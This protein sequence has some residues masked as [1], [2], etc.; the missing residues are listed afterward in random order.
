ML[1]WLA[2]VAINLGKEGIEPHLADLLSPVYRELEL[3]TT[4]KGKYSRI[5]LIKPPTS[6]QN[7]IVFTG[8]QAMS[9]L[10]SRYRAAVKQAT[11]RTFPTL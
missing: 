3:G 1:R 11:K 9:T 2:A 4:Y 8:L 6:Q 10:S 5:P 7:M